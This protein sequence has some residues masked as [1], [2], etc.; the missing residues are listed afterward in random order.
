MAV[1]FLARERLSSLLTVLANSGYEVLGPQVRDGAIVY[2][3]LDSVDDLPRGIETVQSPGKYRLLETSS[4]R[5]FNWANGPGAV[6]PVLYKARQPLWTAEQAGDQQQAHEQ[7]A[8][9]VAGG[10]VFRECIPEA[11]AR[12]LFGIRPC[13]LAAL[14]IHDQH[15]LYSDYQDRYY[16]AERRQLLTVV[17]NCG[18]C[19][20][21]CFCASTGDGPRAD[22][23][24]DILMDELDT[25]FLVQAGSEIGADILDQL[26]LDFAGEDLLALA[27][28]QSARVA[29]KQTRYLINEN[30][31]ANLFSQLDS[32]QWD[33]IAERCLACGNC[34]AVCPTCFCHRETELPQLDGRSTTHFREWDSCFNADHS[35]MHGRA[36]RDTG[37]LRYRQWMLHKLGSWNYQ[38]GRSG[39]VG[40]GR[41]IAWCPVGI[42]FPAE[43]N[44]IS[45]EAGL[46]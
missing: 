9:P 29:D 40:C 35:V 32:R 15:F 2:A 34:T 19:S 46:W 44:A 11:K 22:A 45:G 3:T 6:K 36:V 21:T 4:S 20:D 16:E 17:V 41:C 33:S 7:V 23:G 31:H 26:E 27:R 43:A 1:H 30:M 13:D 24:Y 12:A 8:E 18:E 25:G 28:A 5:Y 38:Y 10:L 42:D 14:K 37:E 39:C